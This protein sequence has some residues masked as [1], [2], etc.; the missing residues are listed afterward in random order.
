MARLH[1]F[2]GF[3]QA[4]FLAVNENS[5]LRFRLTFQSSSKTDVVQFDLPSGQAMAILHA[6]Q[7]VQRRRGWRMPYGPPQHRRPNLKVVRPSSDDE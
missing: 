1:V 5:G 7:T 3:S 6:L 4:E 2:G